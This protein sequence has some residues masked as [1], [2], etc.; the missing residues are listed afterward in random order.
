MA[1]LHQALIVL[2]LLLL[3]LFVPGQ[4]EEQAQDT[5]QVA[6]TDLFCRKPLYI[7]SS[8]IKETEAGIHIL[9]HLRLTSWASIDVFHFL[10]CYDLNDL[11]QQY[12]ISDVLT[13]IF[14]QTRTT[15]LGQV[16]VGPVCVDLAYL[17]LLCLSSALSFHFGRFELSFDRQ[18]T[19][20]GG[21]ERGI[22]GGMVSLP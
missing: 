18:L 11:R 5:L 6:I 3:L 20:Q 10:I 8:G 7:H 13:E 16:V 14:N 17:S 15:R 12:S 19:C 2:L 1:E 21:R 22:L 9:D 4:D